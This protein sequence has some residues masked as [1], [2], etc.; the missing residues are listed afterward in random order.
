MYKS[1]LIQPR[2]LVQ[3]GDIELSIDTARPDFTALQGVTMSFSDSETYPTCSISFTSDIVGYEAYRKCVSKEYRDQPI[4]ITIGYP[5][6]SWFSAKFYYS[7][8]TL[9]SGNTGE[10]SITGSATQ[11]NFLSSFKTNV[12]METTLAELP[13]RIQEQVAEGAEGLVATEFSKLALSVAQGVKLEGILG[14]GQP[15]G[16]ILHNHLANQGLRVDYTALADPSNPR[17]KISASPLAE[18]EDQPKDSE[19]SSVEKSL[20]SQSYGFLLGPG[21]IRE[22][23]RGINWGPDSGENANT[24]PATLKSPVSPNPSAGSGEGDK[25]VDS[26]K[27]PAGQDAPSVASTVVTEETNPSLGLDLK[28]LQEIQDKFTISGSFFMVPAVVGIKPHDFIFLPSLTEDYVE[29]WYVSQVE[30]SFDASGCQ[31]SFSGFRLDLDPSRKM[32]TSETYNYFLDKARGLRTLEDWEKYY[33]RIKP[34]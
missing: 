2:M 14:T 31:V 6:G 28:G 33:W 25:A 16:R 9:S 3:W 11:K 8:V 23:T 15:P 18:G 30:Y 20:G 24:T 4:L 5:R 32:V 22:V 13:Q 26:P 1:Q 34:S 7:G 29:D 19:D 21:L 10:I 27:A 17:A 12:A